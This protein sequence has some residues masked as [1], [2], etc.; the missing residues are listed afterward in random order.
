MVHSPCCSCLPALDRVKPLCWRWS[1][2][3]PDVADQFSSCWSRTEYC[4]ECPGVY[5]Y[6]LSRLFCCT[7]TILSYCFCHVCLWHIL[8]NRITPLFETVGIKIIVITSDY[9]VLLCEKFLVKTRCR[10]RPRRNQFE[11]G[12]CF[13]NDMLREQLHSYAN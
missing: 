11:F 13:Y 12:W 6:T 8:L 9:S 7:N 1:A 2:I 3:L 10:Q 5:N 4:L